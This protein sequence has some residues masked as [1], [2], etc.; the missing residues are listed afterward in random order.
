MI[1][2]QIES[3]GIK[4]AVVEGEFVDG[5]TTDLEPMDAS[6]KQD[7]SILVYL[8]PLS[9]TEFKIVVAGN[10]SGGILL[11]EDSSYMFSGMTNLKEIK[12]MDLLRWVN[13][14]NTDYMFAATSIESVD[15]GNTKIIGEAAFFYCADLISITIPNGVTSIGDYAFSNC[16]SLTS[17][18]IPNSVT[19]IGDAA[20]SDCTNL[21]NIVVPN[22][23]TSIGHSVFH[24]SGLTSITIPNSV[25]NIAPH[26][27]YSCKN[28]K[29]IEIPN[30]VTSIGNYAFDYSTNLK[31]VY[32]TG[33]SDDWNK[34]VIDSKGNDYLINATKHYEYVGE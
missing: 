33:T 22:S 9:E 13:V 15:L 6:Y 27:F 21:T 12:G 31:D 19:S 24:S 11:N 3:L 30:S 1:S 8:V 23:V 25:T 20:F 2:Q 7:E 10:G 18:E 32:Y 17:V 5:Y 28:L 14:E 4:N 16:T 34:I 26:V 29:S